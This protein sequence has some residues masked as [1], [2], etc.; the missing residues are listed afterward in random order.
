MNYKDIMHKEGT[1]DNIN[2]YN[3]IDIYHET[4]KPMHIMY[5]GPS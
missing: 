1:P 4:S 5:L 2:S 3:T